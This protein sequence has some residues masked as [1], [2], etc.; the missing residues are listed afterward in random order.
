MMENGKPEE[1]TAEK[2]ERELREA[3]KRLDETEKLIDTVSEE[4]KRPWDEEYEELPCCEDDYEGE[5]G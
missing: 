4:L 5:L 2:L 3:E 1:M